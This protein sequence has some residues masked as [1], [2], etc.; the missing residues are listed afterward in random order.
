MAL[1]ITKIPDITYYLG[2]SGIQRAF[3]L[4]PSASDYVPGGYPITAAQVELGYLVGA[5]L[6]GANAAG[7]TYL[8]QFV[9]PTGLFG[10][11]PA[12]GTSLKLKVVDSTSGGGAFT[13]VSASTDLS[14]CSWAALIL[15]W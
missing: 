14:G 11:P 2:E 10:T 3:T 7:A 12:V 15:G 8:A 13:E 1:T 6:L 4:T 9:E 5:Q